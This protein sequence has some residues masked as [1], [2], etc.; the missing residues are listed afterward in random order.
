MLRRTFVRLF[1]GSLLA[2]LGSCRP[3][4]PGSAGN[5]GFRHGV[6][7]G[8]PLPDGVIIWTRVSG[9]EGEPVSVSWQVATDR[10]M[11]SI[12]AEGKA[13]TG[14]E[15]DYTVKVDVRGL[16]PGA[17]C[18]Y[19]F[20]A[21]DSSSPI[22]STRTLPGG[23]IATATFA[24]VSCSSYPTGFFHAYREIALRD[25]LDAVVHLGDY[26]YEYGL[27][28]YGT[29]Y[30]EALS[31]VP[32]PAGEARSL[33]DYRRRHAQYKSDP[34][35]QAMHAAHPLIAVWDDHEIAND[36]WRGGAENHADDEGD[37]QE[38]VSTAVQAYLE[39]MPVRAEAAGSATR[40]YREFVYG[41][42]LALLMLDTRLIG[43]D[44]QPV[45]S[46]DMGP[47]DAAAVL[48]DTDRDLLGD[49]Q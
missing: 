26:L 17:R 32:E 27:G 43:R 25:D 35:S 46:A 48:G 5:Y 8:D 28:E 20:R 2:V 1:A 39:W 40:I 31:R 24:V 33:S 23:S 41:D 30:A 15:K 47:G 9:G 16:P 29:E 22:G 14:P 6:A 7:S 18:Y 19:R 4:K 45:V 49:E 21:G 42:L 38:R 3:V 44:R 13:E 34:D 12:V 37:W 36:A 11:R 10:Q